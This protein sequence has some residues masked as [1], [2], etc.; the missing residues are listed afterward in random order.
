MKPLLTMLAALPLAAC[1]TVPA[2]APSVATVAVGEAARLGPLNV[3]VTG[4]IEDSRCPAQVQCIWKGR[5]V[6]AVIADDPVALAGQDGPN[7]PATAVAHETTLT[8]DEPARE[9][10]GHRLALIAATPEPIAGQA[11]RDD[12]YRLTLKLD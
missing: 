7:A 2:R 4:I 6:V 3:R 5:L 12:S 8:L 9:V 1:M 10:L 11:R